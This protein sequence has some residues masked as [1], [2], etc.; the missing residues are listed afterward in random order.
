[1]DTYKLHTSPLPYYF[2][3]PALNFIFLHFFIF[4]FVKFSGDS[5][6]P[7]MGGVPL[8]AHRS[9]A[10]AK[11]DYELAY[12][13]L[14]RWKS[15]GCPLTDLK[16]H[17]EFSKV[18]AYFEAYHSAMADSRSSTKSL[19]FEKLFSEMSTQEREALITSMIEKVGTP[20]Q[21]FAHQLL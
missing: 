5:S 14:E 19:D 15:S 4:F 13:Q 9:S 10:V 8:G 3:F 20:L 6:I 7:A 21:R 17:G 11:R 18:E 16:V 2:P 12:I 1:M